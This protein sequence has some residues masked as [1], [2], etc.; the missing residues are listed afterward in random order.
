MFF[1]ENVSGKYPVVKVAYAFAYAIPPIFRYL[2]KCY[3]ELPSDD[4]EVSSMQIIK[5]L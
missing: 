1:T 5:L 2:L 4:Y 3:R